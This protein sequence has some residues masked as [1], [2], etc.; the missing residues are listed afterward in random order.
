MI[1]GKWKMVFVLLVALMLSVGPSVVPAAAQSFTATIRGT[2]K[3]QSGAV[4]PGANITVQNTN[5]GWTRT[6]VT[7][8]LGD[9]VVTQLPAD[10]YSISA[11]LT[12]FKT[13]V[14]EAIVLQVGQEARIDFSLAVGG[15]EEKV[16]VTAGAPLVQSE[17]AMV[18]NV[19]DEQKIKEMPLNGRE[20]WQLARLAPNVFEPP[21][22]STLGFRGGFNVAG[23]PE[24][25]NYFLLDGIDNNDE[26][27][28]QPTH[29]P[30]VDGI[31]EFKVLTG[32]YSAEYGR[33]SGGQIIITTKSGTNEFHGTAFEFLRNDNLDARN[34]FLVGPKPEL[35]RNQFGGSFGGPVFKDRTFFFTTYEGLRLT[36]SVA[37]LR[38]VPT[39]KMRR[40]DLSELAANVFIRD[41]Q[42]TGNCNATDQTACFPGRIIP[43][44]RQHKTSRAL[45]DF[46]PRANLPGTGNNFAFNGARTQNQNQFS[47][48]IDHKF[49]NN[50]N[51]FGSYQFMQRESFE[52]SNP[53][54]GDRGLPLFSCTEPERTQHIAL[55]DTHVFSARLINEARVGYNRLRTNR[56]QD[57]LALGNVVQKLGLPQGGSQGLAGPEFFNTGV[58]QVAV[59]GFA[60][61]GGPTNLPQ[62][63]RANTYHVAD[64][65]TYTSGSHTIKGGADYKWFLFNSFFTQDGRGNFSFNGA[66]TGNAFAD[67]L[68][69]TLRTAARAPGEPFS[70]TYTSQA[71]FYAQD[72]WKVSQKLTLN[73]GFRYELNV[74]EEERVNKFSSFDP[75]TGRV[76]VADGRLLDVNPATG[77]LVTVGTSSLGRRMWR[78]DKNN[79]APRFGFAYRPFGDSSTVIRGGYGVFYNQIVAGNGLSQMYRGIPFRTRQSITNTPTQ[80][81][82]TWENLFPAGAGAAAFTPQGINPDFPSAYIQQWSFGVQRELQGNMVID[83]TYLGS[84][85]TRLPISFDIN[86]PT[87][88]AGA[89]Q[90]RRPYRQWSNINFRDAVGTSNY[91]GFSLRVERRFSAGLSFLSQWTY[92]KSIDLGSPP[93]TAGA[94]EAGVMNP[95]NLKGERGLSEFDQRHNFTTSVVYELPWG[96][97]KRWM[98]NAP[99]VVDHI[100]GGWQLTGIV[101][102]QSGR[103]FTVTTGRDM[104]NTGGANR[105][106]V[107]GNPKLDKP[108]ANRWFNTDAFSDVLPAGVFAYGSAGKNI[109]IADGINN[110]DLGLFKNF[111]LGEERRLQFRAEFF[112]AANHAN[113]GVPER[114]RQSSAFGRVSSTTTLNRQIQFGLK[115]NF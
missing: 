43:D 20:F 68:L 64:S 52:P 25:N 76:P 33:Q 4:V 78:L 80:V 51:L 13:E 23:N 62:G 16:V 17:N 111:N 98:S 112:N 55:V 61:I 85:G 69:G 8:D 44:A 49:S 19:I 53:L 42:K 94:G 47:A 71:G 54:C 73:F 72:D 60:T 90:S 83:L 28:A 100:L 105:P 10:T 24:V 101:R 66:F 2:V 29:R 56:F 77:A 89:I 48:R 39:D 65:V 70:N 106:N 46:W 102:F 109:L 40:G 26:T 27:T 110:I 18:G 59:T 79:V 11:Q 50:N 35:K 91:H 63:R 87:P 74:P 22:G 9:Y 14:R 34:F 7:N 103:P 5:K 84:K 1:N 95:K 21:A 97:G 6:T 99:A 41:P 96:R 15:L 113:F 58:P 115:F 32:I 92:S 36:E 12:G 45:L 88:A 81:I 37:R 67:F 86:Q 107:V 104:S 57:D 30:S 108:T 3:D 31:R 75:A 82:S 114:N 93:S 38:T